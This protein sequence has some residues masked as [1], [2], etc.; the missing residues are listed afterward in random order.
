MEVAVTEFQKAVQDWK[1]QSG[2]SDT[3][4]GARLGVSQMTIFRWRHGLHLPLNPVYRGLLI[5]KIRKSVA[6]TPD[7]TP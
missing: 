7:P 2:L 5:E 6:P 4:I 3:Q 1:D